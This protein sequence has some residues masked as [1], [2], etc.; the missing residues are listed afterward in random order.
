MDGELEK[1]TE[2]AFAPFELGKS[3]PLSENS[4]PSERWARELPAAALCALSSGAGAEAGAELET[5]PLPCRSLGWV[6]LGLIPDT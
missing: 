6:R 2:R 3:F 4:F 1:S 5:C